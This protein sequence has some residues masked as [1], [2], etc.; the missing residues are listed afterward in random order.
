[1][2]ENREL[3][4]VPG[5]SIDIIPYRYHAVGYT[6]NQQ[7]G[8]QLFIVLE[9]LLKLC[10]LDF[11]IA[12]T[13]CTKDSSALS[14]SYPFF[15]FHFDRTVFI[16]ASSFSY[17]ITVL[18]RSWYLPFII[19]LSCSTLFIIAV[20]QLDDLTLFPVKD[21]LEFHV[22]TKAKVK[23]EKPELSVSCIKKDVAFVCRHNGWK[24][25]SRKKQKC[26][27]N[28]AVYNNNNSKGEKFLFFKD[29]ER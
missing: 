25:L 13:Y 27:C 26:W 22:I 4:S 5:S 18:C 21:F 28:F 8:Q 23:I 17:F 16:S 14:S 15:F 1:M 7:W 29:I 12:A 20:R 24:F 19:V 2:I 6:G 9:K 3:L 11:L 10:G